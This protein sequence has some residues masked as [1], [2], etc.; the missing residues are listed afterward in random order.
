MASNPLDEKYDA[1]NCELATVQPG[2]EER[3][4]IEKYLD[5]TKDGRKLTL[6]DLFKVKRNGE[7]KVFNPNKL[8]TKKLLWHGSRFSN[9]GGI[10]S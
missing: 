6:L 5:N 8:G 10:L 2:T 7:D 3:K 9:F 4:M 1:L